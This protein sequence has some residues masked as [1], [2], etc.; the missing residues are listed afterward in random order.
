MPG[1]GAQFVEVYFTEGDKKNQEH[2]H[3]QDGV[4]DRVEENGSLLL[5][6]DETEDEVNHRPQTHRHR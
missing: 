6:R 2:E 3:R 1:Y 4:E 5:L